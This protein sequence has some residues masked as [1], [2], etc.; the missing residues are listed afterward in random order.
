MNAID[1]DQFM[2]SGFID[3]ISD[4]VEDTLQSIVNRPSR[5]RWFVMGAALGS[6]AMIFL[7]PVH[8]ERRRADLRQ[9]AMN[10][11]SGLRSYA[12]E[13]YGE[14]QGTSTSSA[15]GSSISGTSRNP[16]H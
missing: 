12:R 3:R 5:A 13:Q 16:T 8:G 2:N 11:T 10:L 1:L 7:D 4:V 15:P 14:Y 6:L 9:R